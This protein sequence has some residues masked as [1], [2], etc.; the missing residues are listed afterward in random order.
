MTATGTQAVDRAAVLLSHVL[1]APE[2]VAFAD[3]ADVS[4]LPKS[5]LSR[6]LSSLERND[7]LARTPDGAFLP[8]ASITDYAL[9]ARSHDALVR[10]AMPSLERLGKSTGE[11]INLAIAVGGEVRQIAQVD[12]A[13][14]LGA[15]NWLDRP[16]PF[17]CSALGKVFLAHGAQL[18]PGRLA[19]LTDRTIT[20]RAELADNVAEVAGRGFA[21]ADGELE[22]G[23]IAIAAPILAADGSVVA[24]ISVSGPSAR[25]SPDDIP[26]LSTLVRSTA[27]E[28]S[29]AVRPDDVPARSPRKAGAA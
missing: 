10:I 22:P 24:A 16:V 28:I 5:T 7:L 25:I 18:P 17:H 2:P 23:L 20:S 6:L 3:L 29:R 14:V 4:G 11:T 13:F 27:A 1:A 15:T 12:C 26:R 9:S 21:V 8:G 19:R